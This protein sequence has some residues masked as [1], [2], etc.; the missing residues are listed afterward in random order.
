MC[1]APKGK[2]EGEFGSMLDESPIRALAE[3]RIMAPD[4]GGVGA[5]W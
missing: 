1:V 4:K 3:V 5:A 2:G